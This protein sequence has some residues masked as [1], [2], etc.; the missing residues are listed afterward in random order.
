MFLHT[1][2]A[3]PGLTGRHVLTADCGVIALAGVA[4]AVTAGG[5]VDLP[6]AL[7]HTAIGTAGWLAA[8][9]LL[10]RNEP[11]RGQAAIEL[12]LVS[13]V[14]MAVTSLVATASAALAPLGGGAGPLATAHFVEVLWPGALL[15][16]LLTPGALALAPWE[17]EAV[18]VVGT[19]ALG[20]YTARRIQEQAA[21]RATCSFLSFAGDGTAGEAPG[22]VLGTSDDLARVLRERPF[23]EVYVAGSPLR[24]ARAMQAAVQVCER[25]GVPFALPESQFR[26]DRARP[27]RRPSADG[28]VHYLGAEPKPVQMALKRALDVV[29]AAAALV[30]LS[31]LLLVVSGLIALGSPGPV[32]FRQTRVGRHGKPF[33]MLKLRSMVEGAEGQR[34]MLAAR[35]EQSG[36]VFKIRD[37]PRVTRVGR[38]I[39]RYSIDELPQLVNVLCGD[40]SLVGPRPPLP[41]EVARYEPWQRRRLSVRPG[42]TCLWQVSGRNAVSFEEW[43][44]LD[45]RYIDHWS[46]DEDLKLILRT[47]PAVVTGRGAS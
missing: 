6:A 46:L 16:R 23:D 40:M 28:Y 47:V 14:V 15:V 31:P 3:H 39:R 26:L 34:A 18:L 7:V 41:E 45:M 12:G 11:G 10:Q 22:E 32:L 8:S 30:L 24:H 35:N 4:S 33:A 43:M 36:P 29:V 21:R 17:P 2:S 19:G 1:V 25:F 42:I 9:R 44:Y 13:G 20:R 37:D 38:F 27:A 5:G